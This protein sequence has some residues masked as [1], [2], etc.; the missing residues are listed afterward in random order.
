LS[1][2]VVIEKEKEM[3]KG[4]I[5]CTILLVTNLFVAATA[6]RAQETFGGTVFKYGSGRY[7]GV[8]TSGFTLTLKSTTP[9]D[10]AQRDLEILQSGGQDKLLDAIRDQDLGRFSLTGE[11]GRTINAVRE[12]NVG[13]M[14]KIYAVF[15]RWTQFAELRNGYRSLDY[16][17]GY[18]ELTIDPRTGKGTGQY[19]AAAKIRWKTDS[20]NGP[21]VEVEDYATFPAKLF[22]VE[23]EGRKR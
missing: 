21:H 11:L 19:F 20:K 1:Y 4:I 2:K 18:I 14:R 22:N 16:P 17:F 3:K 5:I 23:T 7:T 6:A 12:V 8:R 9:E 15:E 10:Q 13:G